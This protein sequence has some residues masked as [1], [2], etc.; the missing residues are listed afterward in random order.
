MFEVSVPRRAFLA[1]SAIA[2]LELALGRVPR[3]LAAELNGD[4]GSFVRLSEIASGATALPTELAP[5]Y[6]VAL[7]APGVLKMK[8]STF[9]RLAGVGANG[10]PST[11]AALERSPAYRAPGGKECLETIAAS[12]W[13]GIV[14][15]AGGGQKVVTF[16]EAL[17]YQH[18]HESTLCTGVPGSWARPGTSVA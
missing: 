11:V 3:S 17:V 14:P 5:R 7:E 1:G 9:A 12:W 10:G 8:P 6:F 4:L 18:V 16:G 13:S 15:T 2:A